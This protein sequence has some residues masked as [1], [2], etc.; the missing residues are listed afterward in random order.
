MHGSTP[1]GLRIAGLLMA[2]ALGVAATSHTSL[3]LAAPSRTPK[4]A[5][6]AAAAPPAPRVTPEAGLAISRSAA[7][8]RLIRDF[9]SRSDGG[10]DY[11][12]PQDRFRVRITADGRVSFRTTPPNRE[13]D[14]C[15][16]DERCVS[17]NEVVKFVRGTSRWRRAPS[18]SEYGSVLQSGAASPDTPHPMLDPSPDGETPSR[19]LHGL[20]GR[21]GPTLLSERVKAEFLRDTFEFRLDLARQAERRR[22]VAEGAQLAESLDRIWRDERMSL[23]SRRELLFERWDRCLDAVQPSA[24]LD[25]VD[26]FAAPLREMRDKAAAESRRQVLRFIRERAP[27]G[28]DAVYTP[29]EL[30]RL[31]AR[32]RCREAFAPYAAS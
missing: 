12:D 3:A 24:S 22:L 26:E 18:M 16:E 7:A 13:L 6:Q 29:E 9:R 5:P 23:V 1:G 32:R 10:Y 15:T 20:G 28:S 14:V 30:R 2:A 19:L 17:D 11:F 27:A 21:L 4:V 25:P 31:N 8:G